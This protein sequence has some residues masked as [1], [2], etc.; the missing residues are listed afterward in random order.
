MYT[1]PDG[2][3]GYRCAAEPVEDYVKKGGEIEA[4]QGRKCLCNA[5]CAN[6]GLA[7]VQ[8][9][10]D[11]QEEILI[12]IGDDVN[13]CRRYLKQNEEGDWEYSARDVVDFLLSDFEGEKVDVT[14]SLKSTAL[15]QKVYLK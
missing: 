14:T 1:K 9:K 7:Q 13:N 3:V 11:Y 6:V 15:S 2:S 12:T 5:L 10:N 8:A 4:T